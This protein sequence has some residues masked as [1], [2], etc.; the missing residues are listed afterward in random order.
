LKV[1]FAVPNVKTLQKF[2]SHYTI[3]AENPGVM[4]VP[5]DEFCRMKQSR[6][7]KISIDGKKLG[8]GFGERHGE[9]NLAGE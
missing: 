5:I 9:V 7:L 3:D 2:T 1:N 8:F 4:H 6:F